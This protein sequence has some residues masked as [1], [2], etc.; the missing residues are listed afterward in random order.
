MEARIVPLP[1]PTA[2]P[3]RSVAGPASVRIDGERILVERLVV[4]DGA[5]A[6]R[7]RGAR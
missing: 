3:L 5:L 1:T 4:V 6:A 2:A 7:A